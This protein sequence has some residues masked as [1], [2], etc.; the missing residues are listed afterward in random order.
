MKIDTV[1]KFLIEIVVPMFPGSSVENS[2]FVPYNKTSETVVYDHAPTR[3][4]VRQ[5]AVAKEFFAITRL[6][7]WDNAEKLLVK[8]L[9]SVFDHT[10]T[11]AAPLLNQ[12]EDY[13]VRKAIAQTVARGAQA[14]TLEAVLEILS[15]W[16]SQTYEGERVSSGIVVS[17]ALT[18]T[19]S[20]LS[21]L[22]LMKEDF[23]KV[24]SDGVDSWW[25]VDQKRGRNSVQSL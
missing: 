12:L 22:E 13:V 1:E 15:A 19:A 21:L 2:N 8:K 14:E 7:S 6:Q 3:L 24:L 9:L 11:T 10:K 17:A 4:R 23:G 20:K 18:P 16:A 25:R 5:N